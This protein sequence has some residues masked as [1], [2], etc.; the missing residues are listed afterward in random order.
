ML[1]LFT[2]GVIISKLATFDL[3]GTLFIQF[4]LCLDEKG[5][6]PGA[7]YVVASL[8]RLVVAP[9]VFFG[10]GEDGR[11]DSEGGSCRSRPKESDMKER[12][13]LF[14]EEE[15]RQNL[16]SQADEIIEKHRTA[17]HHLAILTSSSNY[18][19]AFAA[20]HWGISHVLCNRFE[21]VDD[22]FTGILIEPVCFGQGK[23]THAQALA[24]ELGVPLSDCVFYTDSY[25][26]YPAMEGGTAHRGSS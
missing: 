23:L 8:A 24:K 13:R 3:N 16:R 19:S 9:A 10:R 20:E 5:V 15:V 17:G 1:G 25:S 7:Y 22:E 26:D 4:G 21:V 18:L 12:V 14:W 2:A 6:S 11:R